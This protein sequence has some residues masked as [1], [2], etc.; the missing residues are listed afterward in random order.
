M[1]RDKK[2]WLKIF[3]LL[4]LISFSLVAIRIIIGE[5][6]TS[7]D[8]EIIAGDYEVIEAVT[9]AT[10]QEPKSKLIS[11]GEYKITA[12]CPCVKCCGVWSAEHPSHQGTDYVQKTASGTIPTEGRTIAA[13]PSVLPYGTVV[14]VDGYEYVVEDT[15]GAMN[16]NAIDIYFSSH[17]AALEWGVQYKT[18]YIKGDF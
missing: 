2:Y 3:I 10:T 14:V 1:G 17:E 9:C 15:G 4:T 18:I 6:F 12:Y 13:D 11:L 7:T 8:N 16:G 5:K